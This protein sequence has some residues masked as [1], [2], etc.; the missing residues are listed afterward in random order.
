[1]SGMLDEFRHVYCWKKPEAM[2]S[3][4]GFLDSINGY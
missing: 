4:F 3:E 1:M 2:Q